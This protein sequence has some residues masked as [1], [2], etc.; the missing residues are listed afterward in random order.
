M[1]GLVDRGAARI[2]ER[3]N[4]SI[5]SRRGCAGR[6]QFVRKKATGRPVPTDVRMS[7]IVD[8]GRCSRHRKSDVIDPKKTL[9]AVFGPATQ[10]SRFWAVRVCC[11]SRQE[12][13][14]E[15]EK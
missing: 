7:G 1:P 12:P 3:T 9:F 13:A 8:S 4:T 2:P 5:R 15:Q 10:D 11:A 14:T 6:L